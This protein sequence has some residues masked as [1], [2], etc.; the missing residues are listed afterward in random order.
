MTQISK[1][2]FLALSILLATVSHG[3]ANPLAG[4]G[5]AAVP[6]LF[7][8]NGSLLQA[9]ARVP[10]KKIV[11]YRPGKVPRDDIR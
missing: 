4:G 2:G 10:A 11:R 7:T 3:Y 1:S 9:G 8:S 5:E 6:K